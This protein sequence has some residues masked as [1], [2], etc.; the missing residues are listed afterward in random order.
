MIGVKNKN[1]VALNDSP[2]VRDI[3]RFVVNECVVG[4][5]YEFGVYRGQTLV[6]FYKTIQ[7]TAKRRI[8][9]EGVIG[10]N[11]SSRLKRVE[12]YNNML[13]HAF[14]SFEGLPVLSN[15]DELSDDFAKGQFSSPAKVI[16]KLAQKH[17]MSLGSIKFHKGWFNQTCNDQYVKNNW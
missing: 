3:A 6:S 2:L 1:T 9:N 8:A 17:S 15:D 5:Y 4:D 13:Y 16:A 10:A 12:I 7:K 11:K 14:D